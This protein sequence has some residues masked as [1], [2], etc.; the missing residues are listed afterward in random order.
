MSYTNMIQLNLKIYNKLFKW[1]FYIKQQAYK[2]II[3]P[4][5]HVSITELYSFYD[6]N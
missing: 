1:M 2:I 3:S 4:A 5:R 6:Q